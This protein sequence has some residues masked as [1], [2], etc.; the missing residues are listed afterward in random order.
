LRRSDNS[1]KIETALV[2]IDKALLNSFLGIPDVKNVSVVEKSDDNKPSHGPNPFMRLGAGATTSAISFFS[3]IGKKEKK[4][5]EAGT[6]AQ[7]AVTETHPKPT[8]DKTKEMFS[9][10][11][12][13]M[14]TSMGI[15][16]SSTWRKNADVKV[17]EG[18]AAAEA[19]EKGGDGTDF[20]IDDNED[21]ATKAKRRLSDSIADTSVVNVT[22]TEQEKAQALAMHKLAGLRKG[23]G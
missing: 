8:G 13:R 20:V 19:K 7:T 18:T 15:F 4:P 14:S 2:D 1:F 11:G 16:K 22:K 3:A 12:K 5:D 9:D 17:N 6:E 10:L 23:D 21:E